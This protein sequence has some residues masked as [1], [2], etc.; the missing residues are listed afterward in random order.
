MLVSLSG[1]RET[2]NLLKE[3]TLELVLEDSEVNYS[4][5]VA[6]KNSINDALIIPSG[7]SNNIKG[8]NLK[9][10]GEEMN[11]KL[12]VVSHILN[13][14]HLWPEVRVKGGAYGCSLSVGKS[15]DLIFSSFSDP[16]VSNTFEVYNQASEYLENFNPTLEEFE[17]Y[18]IG[19][20]AKVTT[21]GSNV[22]KI[23]QADSHYINETTPEESERLIEEILN[24]TIEDVKGYSKLFK[25]VSQLAKEYSV[26]NEEAITKYPRLE[27]VSK[28]K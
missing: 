8:I 21:P 17:S 25:K 22:V 1:D 4:L 13:F 11:G 9:D 20:V 10:L 3:K 12:T 16:N 26:G 28:L 19:A 5:N 2:I 6:I 24:T 15:N 7:V 23:N 27:K 14:D 18:I